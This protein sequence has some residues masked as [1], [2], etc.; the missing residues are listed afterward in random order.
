MGKRGPVSGATYGQKPG[1][2]ADPERQKRLGRPSHTAKRPTKALA[3]LRSV[4]P[5]PPSVPEHLGVVGTAI[6]NNVWQSMPV[7]SPRLD[8]HSVT[9]YCEAAEDAVR[10]RAEVEKRG[11]LIDEPMADPR[12]GILGYKA[13]L[14]PAEAALR[15]ADKVVTE[16]G[17]RLGLTPA[18]RARLGLVISQAE[19]AGAEAGRILSAMFV[20]A[21]FDIEE[22]KW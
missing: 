5:K 19:L 10:A 3:P 22:D 17:D 4:T 20:P 11:L 12:G 8:L 9:R 7:L 6:W 14:N 15:R 18:A 16:L 2:E 21:A 1:P 13:V